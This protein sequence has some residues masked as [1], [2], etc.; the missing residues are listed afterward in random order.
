MRRSH[1]AATHT[2]P[3][4]EILH[5]ETAGKADG[6]QAIVAWGRQW[7]QWHQPS[8][9]DGLLYALCPAYPP[10]TSKFLLCAKDVKA[11]DKND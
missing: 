8:G 5:T 1:R 3:S 4:T 9:G 10:L 6:A 11:D 2:R 7:S